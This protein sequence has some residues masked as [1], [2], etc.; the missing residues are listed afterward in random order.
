ML[1]WARHCHNRCQF[2]P[3]KFC[4]FNTKFSGN[5]FSVARDSSVVQF[6][7]LL[8]RQTL[9]TDANAP[10][11]YLSVVS[12]LLRTLLRTAANIDGSHGC[13]SE[14]VYCCVL[15]GLEANPRSQ[16]FFVNYKSKLLIA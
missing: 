5:Q 12:R 13:Y 14:L 7:T 3:D 6:G 16:Q 9:P 1:T 15:C 8:V 11:I 10:K 4:I 2:Q